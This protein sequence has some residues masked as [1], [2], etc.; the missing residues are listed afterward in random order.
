[1]TWAI[2]KA[3][4]GPADFFGLGSLI[5]DLLLNESLLLITDLKNMLLRGKLQQ[6]ASQ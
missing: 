6:L 1:M 2:R 5:I 4:T 3:L